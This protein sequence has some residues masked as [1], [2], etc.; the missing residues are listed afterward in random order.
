MILGFQKQFKPLI[1]DGSKIHTIRADKNNRWKPG[2][3]I[4]FAIGV[5]TKYYEQFHEGICK[6]VQGI[7][8]VNHGNFIFVRV[9][10]D[11]K[12]IHSDCI[13]FNKDKRHDIHLIE[14]IT[15]NDGLSYI[16]FKTWFTPKLH[17]VF[18]GKIIHWTNF[19]YT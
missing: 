13:D 15:Q 5:R 6:S 11:E 9:G 18:E 17:D 2:R 4:H 7:R 1:L 3:K 19:L 12:H 14:N 8:I 16:E 10:D